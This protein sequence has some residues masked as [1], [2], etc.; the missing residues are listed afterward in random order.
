M[1]RMTQAQL[2]NLKPLNEA[3]SLATQ[4]LCQ[5]DIDDL[6]SMLYGFVRVADIPD[7]TRDIL[8]SGIHH[9]SAHIQAETKQMNAEIDGRKC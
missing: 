5:E 1:I 6:L 2:A 9:I 4:A 3:Q 8:L 7:A